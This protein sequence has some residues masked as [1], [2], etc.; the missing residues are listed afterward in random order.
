MTPDKE[1]QNMLS[2]VGTESSFVKQRADLQIHSIPK[3]V[4]SKSLEFCLHRSLRH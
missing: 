4:Q 3:T 2:N 1:T